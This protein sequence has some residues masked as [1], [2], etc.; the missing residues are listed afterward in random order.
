MSVAFNA[1]EQ[2][3][4]QT[5]TVSNDPYSTLFSEYGTQPTKDRVFL[6]SIAELTDAEQGFSPY[7]MT[8]DAGRMASYTDY[9]LLLAFSDYD[10]DREYLLR[11]PG[12]LSHEYTVTAK[13]GDMHLYYVDTDDGCGIRPVVCVD[14]KQF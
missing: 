7:A 12:D 14:L 10:D 8:R 13:N 3:Q 6:P 1:G 9:T 2:K 5:A 11:T 4:L